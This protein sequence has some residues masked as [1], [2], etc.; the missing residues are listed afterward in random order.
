MTFHAKHIERI[1]FRNLRELHSIRRYLAMAAKRTL[2]QVMVTSHLENA[3][4]LLCGV[5]NYLH[6][7]LQEIQSAAARLVLKI[8]KYNSLI[9]LHW[10]PV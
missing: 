2:V 1:C 8:C 5:S 7:R 3:N 4:G 9:K 6:C 10:L